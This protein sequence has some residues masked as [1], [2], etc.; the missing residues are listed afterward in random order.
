MDAM[1]LILAEGSE[2]TGVFNLRSKSI[3][4]LILCPVM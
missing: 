1:L 4:R 2:C 3:E